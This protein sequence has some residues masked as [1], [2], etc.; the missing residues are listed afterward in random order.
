MFVDRETKYRY[1]QQ[2]VIRA[3]LQQQPVLLGTSSVQESE[4]LH[5]HLRALYVQRRFA[6]K[7]T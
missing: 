1:I 7:H 6:L 2:L 5:D 4:D 3:R